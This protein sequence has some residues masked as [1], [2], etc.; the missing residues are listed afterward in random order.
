MIKR[1]NK[2]WQIANNSETKLDAFL[3]SS[4][5]GISRVLST[6]LVNRGLKTPDDAISFMNLSQETI[7]NPFLLNDMNKAVERIS[8]A[9]ENKEKIT[10]YGDYDVDGVTSVSIL[11]LYLTSIGAVVDYYIPLR[12]GEG[13]G[14]SIDAISKLQASGTSLLITV[15]TGITA[16]EEIDYANSLG[17]DVVVT[18]HHECTDALPNALAVINPKRRDSTYPFQH[19]AGVGVVYKLLCALESHINQ[20][21]IKSATRIISQKYSDLTAIGT[22][23][24]VMPIID[25]NRII[26]TY[27]LERAEKT[28]KIGLEMLINLC[29]NGDGKASYSKNKTKKRLNSMYVSYTIAPRINAAGRISTASIAVELF[30]SK[31]EAEA[32]AYARQLL[33]INRERQFVENKIADQAIQ[34]VEENSC[35][36][37]PIIILDSDE[38][39]H[40]IV[41]IVSSKVTD[42]FGVPSFLISFEG[43]DDPF[44][45][46]AIGK[47]SGRSVPGMNLVD[48]LTECSSLLVKF[49][50]HELAAGL[51]I[52]RENL[53]KFKKKL[54]EYAS[55]CFQNVDMSPVLEIE[56]EL[57]ID[58]MNLNVAE[59]ISKLEPFG[60]A[61]NPVPVFATKNM[62]LEDIIPVGMNK[63]LRLVLSK[64][65]K[66]FTA[67]M[68]STSPE[69]FW[70]EPLDEVDVAYNLE[71]NEYNGNVSVQLNVKDIKLSD[72]YI[73]LEKQN[74]DIYQQ[75][76]EGTSTL[77]PELFIP[78]R[79][80]FT[81]VYKHLL[82]ASRCDKDTFSYMRLT[83]ELNRYRTTNH[84][85]YSKVKIIIKVFTELNIV[86]IEEIDDFSF[87]F[88]IAYSK[89]KT[90][91][92]KSSLLKKL[93]SMY[94]AK[95]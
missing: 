34:M 57:E 44:A 26:V 94:Q 81:T 37:K 92:E 25:E 71:T 54:E 93:K 27:G 24:D 66:E 88:K 65:G 28:D 74:E 64:D 86:A 89:N 23:A 41:G 35:E 13:Y 75:I 56:D 7:H 80:D 51:T 9:I 18:D 20:I 82:N 49:G 73:Q 90:N 78:E 46:D 30:L 85:T 39:N 60:V 31:T 58:E 33:E 48:A 45:P 43:N 8:I 14:M 29:R 59:D 70:L 32:E 19:L 69:E 61:I 1:K 10:I 76:K 22:I 40:G 5:M 63:H 91:L 21:S 38:W 67:M 36:K 84:L 47:G 42:K 87:T 79:E 72:S 12:K 62:I 77:S 3:L 15:D 95:K 6:L 83:K 68:F 11:Y 53:E 16:F 55:K 4:Q 17:I 2:I 50:G 52:K